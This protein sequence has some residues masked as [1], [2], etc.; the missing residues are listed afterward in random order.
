M[1]LKKQKEP[2]RQPHFTPHI[3]W[4]SSEFQVRATYIYIV[5]HWNQI[6]ES[7][8]NKRKSE[9]D[10]ITLTARLLQESYERGELHVALAVTVAYIVVAVAVLQTRPWRQRSQGCD[11]SDDDHEYIKRRAAANVIKVVLTGGPCGGKSTA[12]RRMKEVL[13]SEELTSHYPLNVFCAAECAT[14]LVEGGYNFGRQPISKHSIQQRQAV[15]VKTQ[16]AIEEAFVAEAEL[17]HRDFMEAHDRTNNAK[18][19][20]KKNREAADAR[21]DHTGEPSPP[22][23]IILCDRG[24]LDGRGFL[25]AS[26]WQSLLAALQQ[27]EGDICARYDLVLHFESVAGNP[28]K[29]ISGMFTT[30]NNKARRETPMEAAALDKRLNDAWSI[31]PRRKVVEATESFDEKVDAAV[32]HIRAL[33]EQQKKKILSGQAQQNNTIRAASPLKKLQ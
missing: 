20:S 8:E 9:M 16:M 27:S 17:I 30:E 13:A 28:Q 7:G 2:L 10:Y 24:T 18:I 23:S 15:I 6:F 31:H 33:I 21:A 32:G 25:D 26:R 3:L 5:I 4:L 12:L 14:M 1:L 19:Q 29:S 22:W 11:V